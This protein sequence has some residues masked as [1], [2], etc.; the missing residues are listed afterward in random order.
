MVDRKLGTCQRPRA[1]HV[2]VVEGGSPTRIRGVCKKREAWVRKTQRKADEK[3]GFDGLPPKIRTARSVPGHGV[4]V[5][6]ETAS[7]VQSELKGI[8]S[9]AETPEQSSTATTL[10]LTAD[11]KEDRG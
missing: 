6:K 7:R 1:G 3:V 2:V 11:A 10:P 5:L 9:E 8:A 4:R